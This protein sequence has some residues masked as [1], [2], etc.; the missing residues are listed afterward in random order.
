MTVKYFYTVLV[1]ALLCT[2]PLQA[3]SVQG[4][5]GVTSTTQ[6]QIS[7][8]AGI[9]YYATPNVHLMGTLGMVPYGLNTQIDQYGIKR[10]DITFTGSVD[11]VVG[12]SK[13][14]PIAAIGGLYTQHGTVLTR[15]LPEG[16]KP[17]WLNNDAG[18][19]TKRSW[20]LIE[21]GV[22]LNFDH[23]VITATYR[24]GLETNYRGMTNDYL[25]DKLSL[26]IYLR[27]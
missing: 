3:K 20:Y 9:Y 13:R 5:L 24:F 16:S 23:L 26:R 12:L 8:E 27:Y 2:V 19:S 6:G 17:E 1:V 21:S 10:S 4:L 7:A 18:W 15:W 14:F 11:L 25:K 22:M